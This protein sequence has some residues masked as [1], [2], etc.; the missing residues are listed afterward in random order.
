M[1]K[2]NITFLLAAGAMLI[3]IF[4]GK[5][6]S[7]A[8]VMGIELCLRTVIPSLFP[9]F[10]LSGL[11]VGNAMSSRF[12]IPLG[13]LFRVPAGSETVLLTGLLGGYPV[14]AKAAAQSY[15]QGAIS[16]ETANRMIGFCSQPG[17]GF[18]FGMAASAFPSLYWG[19]GLWSIQLLSAWL[20]SRVIMPAP[21][22]H[23]TISSGDGFS[24]TEALRSALRITAEVCGWVILFRIIIALTVEQISSLPLWAGC[25]V[26]GLLELTNG[27]VCLKGISDTGLRFLLCSGLLSLGGCCVLM[28]TRSAAP[29]LN[30][31]SYLRGKA[32]QTAFSLVLSALLWRKNLPGLLFSIF[33][34]VFWP[35]MQKRAGNQPRVVV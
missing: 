12:L 34:G 24:L 2:R 29:G 35:K 27:C 21:D 13:R 25:V 17:P 4:Q 15:A 23:A 5:E 20:V 28:Q 22:E 30:L 1:H 33:F 11:L 8:A 14:G 10:V 19:W 31:S 3:L 6:T 18:I 9:F 26:S 7:K 16:R 32:L